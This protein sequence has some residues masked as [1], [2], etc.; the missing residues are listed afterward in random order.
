MFLFCLSEVFATVI[1]MSVNVLFAFSTPFSEFSKF[2]SRKSDISLVQT[3]EFNA[4]LKLQF[5]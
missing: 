4:S 5:D 2:S 3:D 1:K